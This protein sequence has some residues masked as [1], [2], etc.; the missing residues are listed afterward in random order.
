[1]IWASACFISSRVFHL[2]CPPAPTI[3]TLTLSLG[4]TTPRPP[5]TCRG[6]MVKAAAGTAARKNRR[7]LVLISVSQE[8]RSL[9]LRF[10]P[11]YYTLFGLDEEDSWCFF[12]SS[13]RL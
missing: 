5:S 10:H 4:G 2:P 6:R 9:G 1:M 7:R 12:S 8:M 13:S 3:A 11:R